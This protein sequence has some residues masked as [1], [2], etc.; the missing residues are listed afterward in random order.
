MDEIWQQFHRLPR[1]LR[2]AVARPEALRLIDELEAKYPHLDLAG[3][4]M[5]VMVKAMPMSDM[6][7]RIRQ[8]ANVSD[9]V[10][11]DIQRQLISTVFA[12]VAT[13]LDIPDELIPAG[14]PTVPAPQQPTPEPPTSLPIPAPMP[15]PPPLQPRAPIGPHAP[16]TQYSADDE[17]E[18]QH[19]AS[20]VRQITN[21]GL[22]D[23]D[24]VA[25]EVLDAHQ[26]AFGDELLTKRAR[27]IIK[28]QL[29]QIRDANDTQAMLTR[30]PKVGGLGLDPDIAGLV[31]RSVT[32]RMQ[33]L[34][35]RGAVAAPVP[36]P[37]PVPPAVPK[38]GDHKP[39]AMP[40][41]TRELPT[42]AP[43]EPT[44]PS[45]TEAPRPSRPIMRPADIPPPPPVV[46]TPP[47]TP[48]PKKVKSKPAPSIVRPA[49]QNDRP[50]M[51]DISP[52][53]TLGPAEE[54]RSMT[55]PQFRRL[56]QGAV[57]STK[58]VYQK[59]QN[60]QRESFS[61]WSEAVT[62]WRQSDVYQ[63][64]LA[65]GR[66]SLEQGLPIGQVIQARAAAQQ[67]YLSENEFD[68]LAD[69]NRRLQL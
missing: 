61:L 49:R 35:A 48:E 27:S 11:Q 1:S 31:V 37:P 55:L 12:P 56:G 18:I 7:M 3:F 29:K 26:L 39:T 15:T 4:V 45:M 34:H 16:T 42:E 38:I 28:A 57:D 41:L 44:L 19:H 13:Y 46:T 25:Q 33:N 69:L 32:N 23:L 66:Q 63:L 52:A 14:S 10:A 30:D 20:V 68:A 65:M 22:P 60:L 40:P 62:G 67:P 9:V 24:A 21:A 53:P 5:E 64:Y 51:A 47:P 6:P 58:H 54:M 8:A 36:I 43:P 2:D 17:A 59:L 50:V